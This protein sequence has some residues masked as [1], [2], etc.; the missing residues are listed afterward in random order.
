MQNIDEVQL[1]EKMWDKTWII[2][3][4][5]ITADSY[6]NIFTDENIGVS[7]QSGERVLNLGTVFSCFPVAMLS[8]LN[9]RPAL[10]RIAWQ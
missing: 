6:R 2:I 5:E 9:F 8:A 10:T 4:D 1:W 7:Q 3:P